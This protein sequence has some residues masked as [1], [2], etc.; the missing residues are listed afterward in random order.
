VKS[1]AKVLLLARRF[2][3][4]VAKSR[5]GQM[6]GPY[7]GPT[8]VDYIGISD[9]IHKEVCLLISDQYSMLLLYSP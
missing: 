8:I 9:N 5:H 1:I 3:F 7:T 2:Q 4:I 6:D